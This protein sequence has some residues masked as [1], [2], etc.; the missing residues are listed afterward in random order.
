M[1]TKSGFRFAIRSIF[2][3]QAAKQEDEFSMPDYASLA[4]ILPTA[5]RSHAAHT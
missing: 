5:L 4:E 2:P 3:H 1:V